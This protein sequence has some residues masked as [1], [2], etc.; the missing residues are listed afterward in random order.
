MHLVNC[1]KGSSY[2]LTKCSDWYCQNRHQMDSKELNTHALKYALSIDII[3]QNAGMV[4]LNS[5]IS[6]S[7]LGLLGANQASACWRAQNAPIKCTIMITWLMI[8]CYHSLPSARFVLH[9]LSFWS[10]ASLSP[11]HLSFGSGSFLS[12]PLFNSS[13][14][15]RKGKILFCNSIEIVLAGHSPRLPWYPND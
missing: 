11:H 1:W 3:W 13:K 8:N 2:S 9:W 4:G 12:Y 15:L 10:L 5:E 14:V 7:R 6:I